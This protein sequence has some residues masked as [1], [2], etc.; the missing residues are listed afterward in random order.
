[1]VSASR[2]DRTIRF[3]DLI[4]GKQTG[5]EPADGEDEL[6]AVALSADGTILMATEHDRLSRWELHRG[7]TYR[8]SQ[9]GKDAGGG[10]GGRS[11]PHRFPP[12]RYVLGG[13]AQ[14]ARG[15]D[16][17]RIDKPFTLHP[18]QYILSGGPWPT[19]LVGVDDDL[20]IYCGKRLL[21]IDDDGRCPGDTINHSTYDGSPIILVI[22]PGVRFRLRAIDRGADGASLGDVYLHSWDGARKR[23]VTGF[24][25]HSNPQLPHAFFDQEFDCAFPLVAAAAASAPEL[26]PRQLDALW[27]D[28]AS[29]EVARR[30]LA[31]WALAAASRN[32]CTGFRASSGVP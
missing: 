21:F 25:Q 8:W 2:A 29:D 22:P 15:Q 28:L 13:L 19:D 9:G 3:W 1:L 16:A 18:D 6:D 31:V 20:E 4:E 10:P 23:L 26:G 32:T 30:Y 24:W 5:S 17:A 14:P 12:G 11:A 7:L 27:A